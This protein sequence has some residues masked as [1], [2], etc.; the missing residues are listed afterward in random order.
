MRQGLKI[1][2]SC[3]DILYFVCTFLLFVQTLIPLQIWIQTHKMRLSA[4]D[5]TLK[6]ESAQI[7]N[8]RTVLE[9][10]AIN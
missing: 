7:P 6:L 8:V 10:S 4:S 1:L 2:F 3:N 5:T 9:Y